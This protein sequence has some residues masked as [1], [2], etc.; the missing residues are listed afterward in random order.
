MRRFV[1]VFGACPPARTLWPQSVDVGS[2]AAR[3]GASRSSVMNL[4]DRPI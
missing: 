4:T 2:E 3:H 1:F